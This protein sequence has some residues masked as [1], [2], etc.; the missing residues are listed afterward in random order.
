MPRLTEAFLDIGQLIPSVSLSRC[1]LLMFKTVFYILTVVGGIALFTAGAVLFAMHSW[2]IDIG[3]SASVA[4]GIIYMSVLAL[5]LLLVVAVTFPGLLLLQPIRLIRVVRNEREAI[6]S[7]QR[8]RGQSVAKYVQMTFLITEQRSTPRHT[9][10]HTHSASL[11]SRLLTLRRLPC[12]SHSWP[13]RHCC[14][15]F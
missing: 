3:S 9:T 5:L 8:F 7:R 11:C 4:D 15:W 12:C 2:S 6:T 14:C 10:Q 13:R 1:R